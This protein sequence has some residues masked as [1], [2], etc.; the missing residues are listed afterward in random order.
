M[1]I[2]NYM[3][4]STSISTKLL[5]GISLL[6]VFLLL[7]LGGSI[8]LRMKS[9]NK[10]QFD[11]KL[12]ET[13]KL[14]DESLATYFGTIQNSANLFSD[15][16]LI[17]KNDE[18]ITSYVDKTGPG[19]KIPMRPLEASQYEADVYKLAR[20]FVKNMPELLGV[21][22]AL[23]SN[24]AFVRYPEE[25]RSDH[26]DSRVR[27]WYKNAVADNGK[28]H[29][30]DAYQT[31]AG[32][33]VIAVSKTVRGLDG[34]MRGVISFD[35]NLS[36]LSE[37]FSAV[38]QKQ[39]KT[40]TYL[41]TDQNGTVLV[42]GFDKDMIFKKANEI[43]IKGLENYSGG[44][45]LSFEE[46]L[47]GDTCTIRTIPSSNGIIPL[48]YMIILPH[49][50]LY[51]SN[52]QVVNT[53]LILI[54]IAIILSVTVAVV[55]SKVIANPIKSVTKI[56]KNISEGDGDLTQRLPI[57]SQD[58]IG[59]LSGYFN[60]TMQ[61][62]AETLKSIVS[63]AKNME[64]AAATLSEST[65][66]TASAANQI[67]ANI[68]SIKNQVIHQSA[69]VEQTSAT[70]GKISATIAQL[71]KNIDTQ[72]SDMAES[73]S[74]IE[75]MVANIESVNQI[76]IKNSQSVGELTS[77]A[78]NGRILIEQT[79]QSAN[80]ISVDS[81]GLVEAIKVIQN[82]AQQTNMLAMN[83][84]IEA[85]HAGSAGAGFAVVSDEI[86]KLAETSDKQSK[87]IAEKLGNLRT[88][89]TDLAA[90]TKDIQEKFDTI[91]ANTQT[92]AEQENVI[93]SAMQE[94]AAGSKQILA[95]I[96]EITAITKDVE[97]GAAEMKIGS[98]Q[99][100]DEMTRLTSVTSEISN[101]M[102]EMNAGIAEITSSM[103]SINDMS[104]ENSASI[105]N[106][107][108]SIGRFKL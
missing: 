66:E 81:A 93:K 2:D 88:A 14:L 56:L 97:S 108:S 32:E 46:K 17:K 1:D 60:M 98:G 6:T 100:H 7:V 107:N 45:T 42:N 18:S 4:K 15:V 70:I 25:P 41:L 55:M 96:H 63:D 65:A 61:K 90:G 40:T 54:V 68:A 47:F 26:Y 11:S 19:G 10:V 36:K 3:N 13:V 83:A 43:G 92:V 95:A 50:E 64:N 72:A 12:S 48:N 58:E 106:V 73:S 105:Q 57:L 37:I 86:R 69:G 84:A 79:A 28:V 77:S 89:I 5:L 53:L 34:T 49:S 52:R 38:Q 99:I 85:A 104:I 103:Q 74:S 20:S 22:L 67:T 29:F 24:G 44:Q 9:L 39:G 23:E 21:S 33:M 35:A 75:E 76:L 27:S 78:E 82:I 16:E 91:F 102:T 8:Y 71:S 59:E 80:R 62:I 87:S 101:S 30:S 31:S 94:Q 51:A